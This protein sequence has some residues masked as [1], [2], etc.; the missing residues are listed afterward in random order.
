MLPLKF[1]VFYGKSFNTLTMLINS[2]LAALSNS[3]LRAETCTASATIA[4]GATSVIDVPGFSTTGTTVVCAFNTTNDYLTGTGH[5]LAG[6]A[7]KMRVT[8]TNHYTASQ[9]FGFSAIKLYT[10]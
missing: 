6:D 4:A 1:M 5:M 8:I 9:T 7:T 3:R 2:N 10:A